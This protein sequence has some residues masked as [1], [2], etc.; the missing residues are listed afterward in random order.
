MAKAVFYRVLEAPPEA[1]GDALLAA[2]KGEGGKACPRFEVEP[3]AFAAVPGS[4]FAYWVSEMLRKLFVHLPPFEGEGWTAKQ[5]LATANDFRFVHAWWEIPSGQHAQ[6]WFPFA[7]GGQFSPFYADMNLVVNW[8][9]HG[10]EV[11]T[12][13]IIR[14]PYLNGN[15]AYVAKNTSSYFRPGLTWPRRTTSGLSMRIMPPGCIFADKGPAVFIE[16]DNCIEL[17]ALLSLSNSQAFQSLVEIQ[18]AAADAAARSYEVGVIQRT[19]VPDLAPEDTERLAALARR[20]WS[21]KRSLDTRNETSHAFTLPALL[22]AQGGT[23]VERAGAWAAR[24]AEAE[25]ELARIQ[26]E[27]DERCFDLY[28]IGEADRRAIAEG[29]G[30]GEAEGGA[31]ED[32][33]ATEEEEGPDA[34]A[35]ASGL[36]SWAAGVAFGRFDPRLATGERP[37]PPAPEPFDPLPA[38]S[39]AMP[40]SAPGP[41]LA[42]NAPHCLPDDPGHPDD[43]VARIRQAFEAVW[44]DKGDAMLRE[45]A[46]ML[47]PGRADDGL[48]PWCRARFFAEHVKRYSKSRRK[49]PVYWE[50]ATPSG[51]YAVWLYCHRFT[52][53]TMYRVL[54][55]CVKPKH[56]HEHGKLDR[57]RAEA[58]EPTAVQRREIAA[59]EGLVTELRAFMEEAE[60]V[61]PLW[62]P[63]LNDGVIINFAPL[64]RMVKLASWRKECADCWGALAKGEHDWA[65]LA[66]RLWPGRVVPKCAKDRSLA[67]AHEL[68]SLFWVEDGGSWRKRK[69]PAEEVEGQNRRR[70]SESRRQL[71][72]ALAQL[73]LGPSGKDSAE[74]V[75]DRMESGAMDDSPAA[76]LLWPERVV[77]KCCE[78]VSLASKQRLELPKKITE[79]SLALL[80]MKHTVAGCPFLAEP[81][82]AALAGRKEAFADVWKALEG[83]NLDEEPI[84]LALWPGRV[85]DKCAQDADLAAK[86]GL[87]CFLWH[88]HP[89]EGLRRLRDPKAEVEQESARR[90]NPAVQSALKSLLEA[91]PPAGSGTRRQKKRK[92]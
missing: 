12:Y 53:D 23:L 20:A 86:H 90:H 55:D 91:P 58:Q 67:I 41:P 46:E 54:N 52:K 66:M 59:Q 15:A 78:D 5:G 31:G 88:D 76:L 62:D 68:E 34:A 27:I 60:R 19:P 44:P 29:F 35:L 87:A 33:D 4:P 84:A 30:R 16:K 89:D 72:N 7:K 74:A 26:A 21:L 71:E 10:A 36:V 43:I 28:G 50:L 2:V 49:A 14:Y 38:H 65:R 51:S 63:D 64:W 73:A 61:A 40:E 82:G 45:A 18:L 13:I 42:A 70:Q 80:V 3:E 83:G 22:Q 75:W 56:A 69:P 77:R 11:K 24:V 39:P 48:R 32:E 8:D 17:L 47:D 81:L 9:Q 1:K 57:M 37:L 25:A 79:R 85:V 6:T 92:R